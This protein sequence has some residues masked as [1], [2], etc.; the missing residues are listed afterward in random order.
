MASKPPRR[1]TVDVLPDRVTLYVAKGIVH[2]P[3]RMDLVGQPG[4]NPLYL[5]AEYNGDFAGAIDN[6]VALRKFLR[7][8]LERLEAAV[9]ERPRKRKAYWCKV[10]AADCRAPVCAKCKRKAK[11]RKVRK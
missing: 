11:R 8:C 6:G 5:R 1:V 7:L 9:P 3:S 10:C 4:M 2:Q